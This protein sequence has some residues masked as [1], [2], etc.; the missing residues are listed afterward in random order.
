[1]LIYVVEAQTLSR[2]LCQPVYEAN[3]ALLAAASSAIASATQAAREALATR[4]PMVLTDYP[5]C[6]VSS[7]SHT[8]FLRPLPDLFGCVDVYRNFP[9]TNVY[10]KTVLASPGQSVKAIQNACVNVLRFRMKKELVSR[11]V[12]QERIWTVRLAP[13]DTPRVESTRHICWMTS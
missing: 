2:D 11:L 10:S 6:V 9:L 4:D 7:I 3:P 13:S 1:M 5:A 8:Y 12:A